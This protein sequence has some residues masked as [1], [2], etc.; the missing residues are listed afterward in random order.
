MWLL[1]ATQL[2]RPELHEISLAGLY[3]SC[4]TLIPELY[5][6]HCMRED[7]WH[8]S[9][10][11][12][13]MTFV[14]LCSILSL[15]EGWTMAARVFEVPVTIENASPSPSPAP[16]HSPSLSHSSSYVSCSSASSETTPFSL[17]SLFSYIYMIIFLLLCLP[18]P[19]F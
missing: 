14:T 2:V 10:L 5:L 9:Q 13:S 18:P 6:S 16:P 15:A 3:L 19:S 8:P 12:S 11:R 17:P 7:T 4:M 1:A